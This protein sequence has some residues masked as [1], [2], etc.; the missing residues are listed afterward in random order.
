MRTSVTL[1]TSGIPPDTPAPALASTSEVPDDENQSSPARPFQLTPKR[2]KAIEAVRFIAAH[3]KNEDDYAEVTAR[4]CILYVY[5]FTYLHIC[6]IFC[7][8]VYL[9]NLFCLFYYLFIYLFII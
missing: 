2:K 8:L 3:L 5:L 7:L 6:L 9:L 4:S 1:S